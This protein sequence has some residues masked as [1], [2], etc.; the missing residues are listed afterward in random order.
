MFFERREGEKGQSGIWVLRVKRRESQK[1]KRLL[2]KRGNIHSRVR[3]NL[4]LKGGRKSP[5]ELPSKGEVLKGRGKRRS[6][7][8]LTT[9]EGNLKEGDLA[10]LKGLKGPFSSMDRNSISFKKEKSAKGSSSFTK[11]RPYSRQEEKKKRK[12]VFSRRRSN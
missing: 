10:R 3:G 2:T 4:L 11:G 1:K 7:T 8:S 6:I 5:P 12:R 9:G